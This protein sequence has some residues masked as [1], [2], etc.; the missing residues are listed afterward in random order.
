DANGKKLAAIDAFVGQGHGDTHS[1]PLLEDERG[2]SET[3]A[4]LEREDE[5]LQV[6]ESGATDE[7]RALAEFTADGASVSAWLAHDEDDAASANED[8]P[9]VGWTPVGVA[10]DGEAAFDLIT[11]LSQWPEELRQRTRVCLTATPPNSHRS[12]H[13]VPAERCVVY[14]LRNTPRVVH[15]NLG[16]QAAKRLAQHLQAPL[17][18]LTLVPSTLLSPL[19]HAKTVHDAYYRWSIAAVRRRL[20]AMAIPLFALTPATLLPDRQE[21]QEQRDAGSALLELLEALA[22][23]AVVTDD[24]FSGHSRRELDVLRDHC[25]MTRADVT[26]PLLAVD[27]LTAVPFYQRIDAVR[28]SLDDAAVRENDDRRPNGLEKA[29]FLSEEA[30]GQAYAAH[31]MPQDA[32][33]STKLWTLCEELQP[34]PLA[35][36][37]DAAIHDRLQPTLRRLGLEMLR[38]EVVDAMNAQG[39]LGQSTYTEQTALD[40]LESLLSSTDFRPAVQQELQGAGIL[41]LLPFIRHGTLSAGTVLHRLEAAI[42]K[43]APPSDAASRKA[44]AML[45]VLRSRAVAHLCKERDYALYLSLWV[46]RRT[47]RSHQRSGSLRSM[48]LLGIPSLQFSAALAIDACSSLLPSWLSDPRVSLR[49]ERSRDRAQYDLYQLESGRTDDPY[50]NEIQRFL[51]EHR[52]LHPVL[53]LYWGFRLLE[54]SVSIRAAIVTIE[55]LLTKC[56]IGTVLSPDAIV[57]VL[58]TLFRV[59][60]QEGEDAWAASSSTLLAFRERVELEITQ[61]PKLSLAAVKPHLH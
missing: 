33:Q 16:L 50:W 39:L 36:S 9:S 53:I 25:M 47:E 13:H 14:W 61:Q 4:P 48:S 32:E 22:P 21:E 10:R 43:A 5:Q 31:M 40:Q 30:F 51:H 24:G 3:N 28:E 19:R 34:H 38:W 29:T 49:D 27:S 58:N 59:G 11:V 45:K 20:E 8:Q 2:N 60:A 44:L 52:F 57:V 26:W 1:Q 15:G 55:G 54:W 7:R 41:S 35:S 37:Q 23:L 12:G 42:N 46:L 17:V 6:E 56:S 18:A